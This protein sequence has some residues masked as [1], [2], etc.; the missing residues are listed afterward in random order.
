MALTIRGNIVTVTNYEVNR[1]AWCGERMAR[2]T[3]RGRPRRYCRTS[4]RQRHYEARR[5]AT[6]RDLDPGDVLYRV[7]DVA[8][9]RDAVYVLEAAL[10]DA[11]M[12][13]TGG[14][15]EEYPPAFRSVAGAADALIR[16]PLEPKATT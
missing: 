2:S 10:Q 12:D 11:R 8:R 9:L 15:L 7:V 1:C 4:H 14:T 6:L 13:L 3:G 5:E 16:T